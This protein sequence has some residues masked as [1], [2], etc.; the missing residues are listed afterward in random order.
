MSGHLDALH[1]SYV[2]KSNRLAGEGE[3]QGIVWGRERWGDAAS[4]WAGI[5]MRLMSFRGK[6]G[7]VGM[8]MGSHWNA[9]HICHAIGWQG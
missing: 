6:A 2:A 1:I 7:A 4:G 5:G 8:W 3:R 9:F